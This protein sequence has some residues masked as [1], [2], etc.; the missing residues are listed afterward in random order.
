MS[1]PDGRVLSDE[2]KANIIAAKF[3]AFEKQEEK[4][5]SARLRRNIPLPAPSK[6]KVSAASKEEE[7]RRR[8]KEVLDDAFED[9]MLMETLASL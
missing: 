9:S 2:A 5:R 6:R 4:E 1:Q 7:Q 8:D 3:A